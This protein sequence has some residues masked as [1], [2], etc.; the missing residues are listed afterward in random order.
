MKYNLFSNNLIYGFNDDYKYVLIT[1]I[2]KPVSDTEFMV[3][4]KTMEMM[5]LLKPYEFKLGKTLIMKGEKGKYTAQLLEQPFE[6]PELIAT[7]NINI[8]YN[9][10]LK[11]ND[12]T[13]SDSKMPALNGVFV[14]DNGNIYASDGYVAYRHLAN[15]YY[16]STGIIIPRDYIDFLKA[17]I[18]KDTETITLKYDRN[19]CFVKYNNLTIVGRLLNSVFPNVDSIFRKAVNNLTIEYE[20]NLMDNFLNFANKVSGDVIYLDFN[21]Q[22]L[23]ASGNN[24]Y[25]LACLK[26]G[27]FNFRLT[28]TYFNNVFKQIDKVVINYEG[29]LKPIIVNNEYMILPVRRD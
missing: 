9:V 15:D 2:E 11:A 19:K 4:D 16:I 7:K 14:A 28:Y 27:E 3:D 25:E 21:N 26:D 24:V 18:S 8:N 17:N 13:A 5:E 23:K 1:E 20:H 22:E 6:K 29:N 12:F 10:L